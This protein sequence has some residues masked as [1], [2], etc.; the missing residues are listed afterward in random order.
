M[1]DDMCMALDN[2]W[3]KLSEWG[4]KKQRAANAAEGSA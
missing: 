4:L 1:I 3:D 2:H